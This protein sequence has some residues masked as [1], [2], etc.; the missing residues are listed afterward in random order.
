[1]SGRRRRGRRAQTLAPPSTRKVRPSLL[2]LLR[3]LPQAA[4]I[5]TSAT[6]EVIAWN[7][8]AAALMLDFS[9]VPRRD[10]NLV[11][12]A[13]LGPHLFG[14][15]DLDAFRRHAAL[16]LRAA[17]ARYPGDREVAG[18][19]AELVAGSPGFASLWDAHDVT[20]EVTLSKTFQHPQVGPVTVNCDLLD[21]TDRDQSVVIYT[22]DPG[23]PSA[24]ALQLLSVIGTQHM[25]VQSRPQT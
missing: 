14:V 10:R 19:V 9:A 1:M 21:I 15:S 25:T 17:V 18:L 16:K 20:A 3:R 2:D 11:R 12:R 8:L 6:L 23:S 5:V 22:A 13:F 7:D 4:A 24:S